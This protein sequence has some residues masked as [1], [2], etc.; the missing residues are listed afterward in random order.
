MSRQGNGYIRERLLGV[1]RV[2]TTVSEIRHTGRQ[3]L[4]LRQL[5]ILIRHQEMTIH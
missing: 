3:L 1:L 5:V 4:C 2:M